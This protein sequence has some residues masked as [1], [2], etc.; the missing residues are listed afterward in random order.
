MSDLLIWMERCNIYS[1]IVKIC[2]EIQ[3]FYEQHAEVWSLDLKRIRICRFC[4]NDF[5]LGVIQEYLKKGNNH[6]N[7]GIGSQAT[8]VW[9]V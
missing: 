4:G 3:E 2:I 5:V 8:L 7:Q 6:Q 9:I 1:H